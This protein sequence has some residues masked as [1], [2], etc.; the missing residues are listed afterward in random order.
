M[1]RV[2]TIVFFLMATTTWAQNTP[3]DTVKIKQVTVKSIPIK[4]NQERLDSAILSDPQHLNLGDLLSKKSHLFIKSYGI[5]SLATI[6]LRGSG[7]GHTQLNWNGI[8]LNSSMNGTTDLALFPLFFMD[9]VSLNYGL[10]SSIDGTGGIGGSVNISTVPQFK[11]Q[12][13]VVVSSNVGSFGQQQ[14]QA[15]V[16]L[17][18]ENFQS[19]TK[20]IHHQADNDFEYKDLTLEGFPTRKVK[21]ASLLQKGVM[22]SFFLK[23]NKNQLLEANL[24]WFDSE[25][26]LPPLIT[27]RENTEFQEDI[28]IKSLVK[29]SKYFDNSTLKLTAAYLD[30]QLNYENQRAGIASKSETKSLRTRA[31]YEFVL[32]K[33]K[34]HSQVKFEN[35]RATADGLSEEVVQNRLELFFKAEKNITKQLNANASIRSLQVL[36][37]QS[38]FLP[39]LRFDYQFRRSNLKLFA[40]AGKNVSYPSLN[41]LYYQPSGNSRLEAEESESV[42]VGT[43][44]EI[45]LIK[46][47]LVVHSSATLFYTNIENY[48]QWEPTAFGFWRPSNLE[49]VETRGA[50]FFIA[51]KQRQGKLKKQL[52]ATYS[53][54]SSK[55]YEKQHEFDRSSGKQLIYIPEHKGNVSLNVEYKASAINLNYQVLGIRY[56]S[57]DNEELLPRYSLLDVGFS[58]QFNRAGKHPITLSVGVKNVLNEEYQAIE[59]RPMPNRNYFIKMVYQF[60]T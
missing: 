51:I 54:T 11:K 60:K 50:E 47:K 5:G 12:L 36:Q 25:R 39:Q 58:Q 7:S 27:L 31:D 59:W 40:L 21:N 29:Y 53:Y 2:G 8:S 20:L 24:W 3:S 52:T 57:S 13:N 6:S 32:K 42:E 44:H 26:N 45:E 9:E 1:K 23:F 14:L 10:S 34:L 37:K 55:N 17:G 41:D 16:K 22:Q 38:Y 35:N 15:K 43:A 46:D 48:I 30:D 28:S 18:K 19:I 33:I 4:S 49:A 56:L